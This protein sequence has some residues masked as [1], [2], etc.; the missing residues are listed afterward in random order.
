MS[1]SKAWIWN[2]AEGKGNGKVD[3]SCLTAFTELYNIKLTKLKRSSRQLGTALDALVILIRDVIKESF[4]PASFLS[5]S[6]CLTSLLVSLDGSHHFESCQQPRGLDRCHSLARSTTSFYRVSRLW[7]SL[8]RS[9]LCGMNL[10][11][12]FLA[13]LMFIS[14]LSLSV[15]ER[16]GCFML[17]C[18]NIVVL[19]SP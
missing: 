15:N 17:S 16:G 10:A 9:S 5:M 14:L 6:E 18:L 3:N 1:S 4:V 11:M 13:L 12:P 2:L 19:Q 8:S 7:H